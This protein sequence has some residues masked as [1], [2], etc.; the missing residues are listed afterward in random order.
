LPTQIRDVPD[1]VHDALAG[2]ARTEGLSLTRYLQRELEQLAQRAQ[3]VRRNAT[4]IRQTQAR[5]RGHVDRDAILDALHEG[6]GD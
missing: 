6:R 4:V 1:E 2:A 5:V 3:M